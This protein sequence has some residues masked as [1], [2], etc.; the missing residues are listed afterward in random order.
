M[1]GSKHG[2]RMEERI[3]GNRSPKGNPQTRGGRDINRYL[4]PPTIS[5]VHGAFN[6]TNVRKGGRAKAKSYHVKYLYEPA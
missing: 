4:S 6:K 3:K 2:E 1:K 5:I